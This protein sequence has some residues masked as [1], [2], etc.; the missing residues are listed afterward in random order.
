MAV[1][2]SIFKTK[3]N[4]IALSFLEE[5]VVIFGSAI[6]TGFSIRNRLGAD[7]GK[8]KR[9]LESEISKQLETR[10]GLSSTDARNAY[11]KAEATYA[12]QVELVDLYID[13][14]YESIKAVNKSIKKLEKQ[15]AK[16]QK[17]NNESKIKQLKKKFTTN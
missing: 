8:T 16:A 4:Q 12:S 6:R 2:T 15:L 10:Y 3:E 7:T 5:Y 13:S 14:R 9:Q 11:S 17:Q 1:Q